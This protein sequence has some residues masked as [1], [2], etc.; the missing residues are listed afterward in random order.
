[1]KEM[2]SICGVGFGFAASGISRPRVAKC[3]RLR[4]EAENFGGWW[5]LRTL[6]KRLF[7]FVYCVC[8]WPGDGH[9]RGVVGMSRCEVCD[10]VGWPRVAAL[11]SSDE[12]AGY[13][14]RA[15]VHGETYKRYK[16]K[17]VSCG[18]PIFGSTGS[19]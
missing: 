4:D 2:T 18:I 9:C 10:F 3:A 12:Y 15:L 1:M 13:E 5:I 17:L 7:S 11:R 19:R 16:K 14:L 6:Q 8:L